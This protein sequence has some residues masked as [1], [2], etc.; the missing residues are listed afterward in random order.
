MIEP[1]ASS[2]SS[3]A[4]TPSFPRAGMGY[5]RILGD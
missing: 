1:T 2:A 3:G 5:A 4:L